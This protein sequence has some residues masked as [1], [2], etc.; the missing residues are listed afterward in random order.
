MPSPAAGP[1]AA[2]ERGAAPWVALVDARQIRVLLLAGSVVVALVWWLQGRSGML[3]PW[4]RVMLPVLAAVVG[5]CG[6]VMV[7]RPQWQ[8]VCSLT[9]LVGLN[10]HLAHHPVAG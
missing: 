2:S 1:G 5:T 6:V 10:V 3:T 4:D 9:S 7:L 8:G